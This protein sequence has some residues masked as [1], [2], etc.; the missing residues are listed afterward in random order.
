[1]RSD[2]DYR[3]SHAIAASRD[4]GGI[5][6]PLLVAGSPHKCDPDALRSITDLLIDGEAAGFGGLPGVHLV[7]Q[8]DRRMIS[9]G[10]AEC[11]NSNDAWRTSIRLCPKRDVGAE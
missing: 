5:R 9:L 3:I 6:R 8:R 4:E 1:M 10:R 2:R 7:H 11:D